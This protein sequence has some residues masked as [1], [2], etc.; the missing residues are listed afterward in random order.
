M[1]ADHF[2]DLNYIINYGLIELLLPFLIENIVISDS[3]LLYEL[4]C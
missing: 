4:P 3:T 1:E 2:F